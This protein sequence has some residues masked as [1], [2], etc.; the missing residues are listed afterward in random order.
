M[1]SLARFR[2]SNS[3]GSAISPSSWANRSR[4]RAIRESKSMGVVAVIVDRGSRPGSTIPAT[5]ELSLSRSAGAN[6]LGA[7]VT[8]R[9]FLHAPRGI[10]E[11]LFPGEKRMARG[12]DADFN[13]PL[14][15]ARVID[16][17]ASA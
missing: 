13:V 15:R 2:F 11:L 12:A 8:P 4:L 16:S 17:A 3:A 1:I 6:G 14:G 5:G 9:E 10:D 7:A